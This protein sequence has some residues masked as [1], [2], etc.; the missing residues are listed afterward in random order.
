MVMGVCVYPETATLSVLLQSN[1]SPS[2]EC[3]KDW[4]LFYS[5]LPKGGERLEPAK[6]KAEDKRIDEM[7]LADYRACIAAMARPYD[8]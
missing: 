8:F 2:V 1:N 4:P 6:S 5:T 7:Q 3:Y